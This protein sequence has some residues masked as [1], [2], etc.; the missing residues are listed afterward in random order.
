M[1]TP[2][3]TE[4]NPLERNLAEALGVFSLMFVSGGVGIMLGAGLAEG[5]LLMIAITTG[6]VLGIAVISAAPISG[7]QFNPAVSIALSVIGKQSWART[8]SYVI[9][10]CLGCV[11][12]TLLLQNIMQTESLQQAGEASGWAATRGSAGLSV[13]SMLILEMIGTFTLMWVICRVAVHPRS[14]PVS[15]GTIGFA[16][17]GTVA[18]LI[19]A[20]GPLTGMSLNPARS[21]GP[22]LVAGSEAAD[23]IYGIGPVVGASLAALLHHRVQS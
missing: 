21:V 5:G 7:A 14:Q 18:C 23:W 19:L 3:P 15:S 22:I 4:P 6:L 11:L 9:V 12:A 1:S 16:V 2:T 13:S 8:T 17:G 20:F 10:Q